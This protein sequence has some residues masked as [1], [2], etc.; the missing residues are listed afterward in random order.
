MSFSGGK[1]VIK[2]KGD[3]LIKKKKRKKKSKELALL[4]E[5]GSI[6]DPKVRSYREE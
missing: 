3:D 2:L 1:G 5:P 6:K 4:E